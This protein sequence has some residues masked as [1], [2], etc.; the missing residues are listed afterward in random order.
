[1][2]V[3]PV[4]AVTDLDRARD[5]YEGK[6]GLTGEETPGGWLVHGDDNTVIYLLA[7]FTDAGSASWP[8]ASFRVADARAA[9]RMLRSRGVRFLGRDELPFELD[10]DGI[11][12]DTSGL[13]V[14]WMRDPDGSVLTIFSHTTSS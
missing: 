3:G 2:H 7:G 9:V 11:S 8:L 5:F 4:I 10:D 14:A 13:R 6:L 1:M 12:S